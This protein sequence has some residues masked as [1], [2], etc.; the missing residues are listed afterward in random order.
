MH[1]SKGGGPSTGVGH[2][3]EPLE[4]PPEPEP[5]PREPGSERKP[6]S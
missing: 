2:P 5:K 1:K 4:T 3:V 6:K